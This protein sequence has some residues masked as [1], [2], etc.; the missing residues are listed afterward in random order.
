MNPIPQSALFAVVF[1][2]ALYGGAAAQHL[3]HGTAH[4]PTA[5]V[6]MHPMTV[7]IAMSD[8]GI[9]PSTV[10]VP[11]GHPVQL[12]LRGRGTREHHYRVVGLVPDDFWWVAPRESPRAVLT[13]DDGHD[14]HGRQLVK[15]RC[16]ISGRHHADRRCSARVRI[17]REKYRRDDLQGNADGDVRGRVRPAPVSMSAG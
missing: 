10:F 14:H 1:C 6:Q 9:A 3:D 4:A 16:D 15:T 8:A 12:M 2:V 13:S 17:R 7:N 11:A 5:D